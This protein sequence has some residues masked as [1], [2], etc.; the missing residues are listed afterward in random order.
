MPIGAPDYWGISVRPSFGSARRA[1]FAR[2]ANTSAIT[3]ALTITGNGIIYGGYVL[4]S[5]VATQK[6]DSYEIFI[7]G[8]AVAFATFLNQ[9]T[10]LLN[11]EH[12]AGLYELRH[13]DVN[14]KYCLGIMPGITFEKSIR[15]QY[16]ET[17]GRTPN[18]IGDIIYT[19][20]E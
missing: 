7:D 9:N 2:A 3:I 20:I 10:W 1:T 4:S 13:D 11:K 5:G 19:L 6:A 16:L 8:E 14:F 17:Y 15:I 12:V 18:I